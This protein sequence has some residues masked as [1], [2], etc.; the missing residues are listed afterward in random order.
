[1]DI[2]R[3]GKRRRPSRFAAGTL[4]VVEAGRSTTYSAQPGSR[5]VIGRDPGVDIVLG[6]ASVSPRQALIERSGTGW[7]VTSLDAANPVWLLDPTGRAQEI[8][9]EL[10]LRQGELLVGACQVLLYPPA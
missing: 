1:M 6:H 5:L 2:L 9:A 4:V 7:L 3:R 8:E 10:G